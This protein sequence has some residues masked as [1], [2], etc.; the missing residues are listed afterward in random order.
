MRPFITAFT[1]LTALALSAGCG[2]RV[3][4]I[5]LDDARLP[6][7]ARRWLADA[8]DE[9]AIATAGLDQAQD[10]LAG[11]Y[12]FRDYVE[13]DVEPRWSGGA[14]SARQRLEQLVDARLALA[15]LEVNAAEARISLARVM[16]VRA[17]AETAVR[18]DIA[19][20]DLEPIV[21][22]TEE[23]RA[24]LNAAVRRI[25]DQRVA[26]D[27]ATTGWWEAY[28]EYLAGGGDNSILWVFEP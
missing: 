27:E 15:R 9:V 20:Y 13:R 2:P 8:E 16:L 12:E 25:E 14:T 19:A 3:E 28:G 22:A 23:A 1:T 5:T 26:V 11:A 4:R 18:H 10:R 21:A 7:D 17:R 24:A 6:L